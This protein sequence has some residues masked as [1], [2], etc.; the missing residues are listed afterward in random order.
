MWKSVSQ[1][2][3]DQFGAYYNIKTREAVHRGE[4]HEAWYLDDGIQPVF[5]K[6]NDKNIRSQFRAEADQLT[7]LAKTHTI[8]VPQAYG[9]GL[10]QSHSFLALQGL[11]FSAISTTDSNL[12]QQFGYQLAQL[13]LTNQTDQFG[14]SFDTWLGP[15]YQPNRWQQDWASFFAE[16]R[17]GWQLQLCKEKAL[18]FGDIEQIIDC[19][20]HKLAKHQ[21]KPSLLHGNLWIENIAQAQDKIFAFD[22]A[23][24]YGDHEIDLAFSQLFEPFPPTFYQAYQQHYPLSAGFEQRKRIYWFYYLINLSYRFGHSQKLYTQL[25]QKILNEILI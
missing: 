4:I 13:H 9:V 7:L 6:V 20:Y 10:S 22:P 1:L 24:Y 3:A 11:P 5:I 15:I 16:Q 12:W 23:C 25:T 8:P 18:I 19:I 21:P 14:F 2:L 17:I